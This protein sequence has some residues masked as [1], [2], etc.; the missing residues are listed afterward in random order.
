MFV[1]PAINFLRGHG[2]GLHFSE[3]LSMYSFILIPWVRW[4]GFSMRSIRSA[5]IF[6]MTAAFGILWS[7]V[8]RLDLVR[9][10]SY[11]LLMLFLLATEFGIIISY[12]TGRYDGLGAFLLSIVFWSMSVNKP[13]PRLIWLFAACLMIPWAGLQYLPVLFAQGVVL[14]LLYPR[15]YWKEVL[16]A[17]LGSGLGVAV[18]LF[19]VALSGR[20]PSYLKF[21]HMQQHQGLQM[22]AEWIRF[23]KFHHT[24]VI[25]ADFSL[26]FLFAAVVILLIDQ[27]RR[28]MALR[29]SVAFYSLAYCVFVSCIL[30][31]SSKFPTYYSYMLSIPL[32]VGLCHELPLCRRSSVRNAVL[33]LGLL[34]AAAGLGLNGIAYTGNWQ[35]RNYN[36]IERLVSPLVRANDVAFVD[37]PGYYAA[38]SHVDD[39]FLQNP[40]W[41]ILPLM[42]AAQKQ[43]ITVVLVTP[44]K[45][46]DILK[47]LGGGWVMTGSTPS[48]FKRSVFDA[49]GLGFLS[50][51][52]YK[53][54]VYR[55]LY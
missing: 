9:R 28:N 27:H 39:L 50:H 55:R 33:I 34:S 38:R 41:D 2:F 49:K 12:R 4:L 5:D 53:I 37:S 42:T 36:R 15:L 23:G 3:M 7:A 11:R 31:L 17:F 32:I 19:A 44:E 30:L 10:A 22:V 26:P 43:S 48:S 8:K 52:D 20:L 25:P 47:G 51:D 13:V 16:S 14:F 18:F 35:E 1:E 40:D 29:R 24:N 45:A 6:F 54:E 46:G 21:V